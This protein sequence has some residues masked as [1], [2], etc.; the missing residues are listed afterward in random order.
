MNQFRNN[1]F[2]VSGNKSTARS[3]WHSAARA[4][5]FLFILIF[6]FVF[7][8]MSGLYFQG[9]TENANKVISQTA[10][11]LNSIFG[12]SNDI[13]V[14]I[15]SQTWEAIHNE[16]LD[17]NKVN[18][19][20]LFYG[21]I[22]GLVNALG[23]PHSFFLTPSLT[24]EFTQE[25][26]GSFYGI[27]AEIGRKNGFLVIIAPLDGSPADKAGL[28]AGDRIL[29]IDKTDAT[30]MS[31]SEAIFKIRGESGQTVVL[32]ILPKDGQEPRDISIVRA[33]IDIPSVKYKI[34]DNIAVIEIISFNSDTST[35][36]TA[37][38][39]KVLQDNPRGIIVDLRNDPGGFLDTAVEITS[40]WLEP[41]QVV[42]RETYGDKRNDVE[43]RALKRLSLAKFKTVVL[44][45]EG[46]AS[47]AEIMAGALQDYGLAQVVGVTTFGK[48]SVQQLI[49]LRDSSSIKLTVARW[50]TPQGRT[51][52][53]Q[54]IKPNVEVQLTADDYNQD[55]DPQ[56]DQ[57]KAIILA[58]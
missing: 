55:L 8:L 25:L 56:F 53:G 49:P 15:F 41:G 17:K 27:G 44:V 29:A 12:N 57:A 58:Q 1:N 46:S 38:A 51:I 32:N 20:D 40:S 6:T 54:G 33:K 13:D 19:K 43:H 4:Y 23:D 35:R 2:T 3:G 52:D 34:V 31:V 39:Q 14:E 28:K 22:S 37:V 24:S 48:G 36:F 42:V 45:N 18:D 47:A 11:E 10:A 30:D 5:I 16:Y 21:A 7:G 50:L 26:D 9:D